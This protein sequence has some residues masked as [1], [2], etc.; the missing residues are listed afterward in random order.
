MSNKLV[1]QKVLSSYG[2]TYEFNT[3]NFFYKV[4]IKK[5]LSTTIFYV[6]VE[7]SQY[8]LISFLNYKIHTLKEEYFREGRNKKK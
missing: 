2:A 4:E 6:S 3:F 8:D 1:I 5:Y 7:I